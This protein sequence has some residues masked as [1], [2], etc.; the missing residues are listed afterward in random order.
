MFQDKGHAKSF[1][2]YMPNYTKKLLELQKH[3]IRM[4]TYFL[5]GHG[6]LR[7]HLKNMGKT[8]DKYCRF[9]QEAG[10]TGEHLPY[11]CGVITLQRLQYLE[12]AFL[13]PSD[14]SK[15]APRKVLNFAKNLGIDG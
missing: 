7:Y 1:I 10:E 13:M 2:T 9:C 8:D 6:P 12:E 4:A 15:C 5:T 11:K 14:I 3:E